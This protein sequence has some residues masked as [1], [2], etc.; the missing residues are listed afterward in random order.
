MTERP[1]LRDK[2][3]HKLS[4]RISPDIEAGFDIAGIS[5]VL[6]TRQRRM[7]SL[8]KNFRVHKVQHNLQLHFTS[9]GLGLYGELDRAVAGLVPLRQVPVERHLI[10]DYSTLNAAIDAVYFY[11]LRAGRQDLVRAL[12]PMEDISERYYTLRESWLEDELFQE[13]LLDLS[14]AELE[15]QIG[16]SEAAQMRMFI[17]APGSLGKVYLL[18]GSRKYPQDWLLC[19][20]DRYAEKVFSTPGYEPF[21]ERAYPFER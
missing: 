1:P 2:D 17:M 20:I 14:E 16:R 19:Q 11:C 21:N 18:G 12:Q 7:L 10:V 15:D 3:W 13:R 5:H 9:L 6:S 8:P 4:A